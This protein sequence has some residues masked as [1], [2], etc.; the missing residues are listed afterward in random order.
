MD[1]HYKSMP[2]SVRVGFST[3]KVTLMAED[4]ASIHGICGATNADRQIITIAEKMSPQQ[5]ANTLLHEVIHAIHT[6]YGLT[7]RD[8]PPS[9]EEYTNLTTNG[10]CAFFQEN[11]ECLNWIQSALAK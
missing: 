1:E 6:I 9:E 10:L 4:D 3:Y 11:P 2:K 7:H 5:T 8:Q